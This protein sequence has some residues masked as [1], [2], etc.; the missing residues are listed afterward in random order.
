MLEKYVF[1]VTFPK[2][3]LI[4]NWKI[5]VVHRSLQILVLAYFIRSLVNGASWAHSEVPVHL[6]NAYPSKS[7]AYFAAADGFLD[8]TN[9][10]HYCD[11]ETYAFSDNPPPYFWQ[12]RAPKCRVLDW[13][14]VRRSA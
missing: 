10:P 13:Q 12:Y 8:N 11:N 5:G 14:E 4:E 1:N 9:A 3:I 2:E 7:D 6:V